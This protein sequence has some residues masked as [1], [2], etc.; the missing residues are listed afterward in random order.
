MLTAKLSR[1]AERKGN[2]VEW[3]NIIG[4]YI[5]QTFR[6]TFNTEAEAIERE[7]QALACEPIG[8]DRQPIAIERVRL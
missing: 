1:W 2:T 5:G 7:K 3:G 4:G 6:E 8:E